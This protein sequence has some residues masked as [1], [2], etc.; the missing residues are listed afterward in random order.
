ME[1]D[2]QKLSYNPEEAAEVISKSRTGVYAL[3]ASGELKSYKDGRGRRITR[4]ALEEYVARK[5]AKAA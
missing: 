1:T 5:E 3:I 2:S 4:R